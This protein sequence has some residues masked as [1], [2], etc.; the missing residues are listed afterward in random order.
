MVDEKRSPPR[1]VALCA[2]VVA[3]AACGVLVG[4]ARAG[5]SRPAKRRLL[6]MVSRSGIVRLSLGKRRVATITP[7][8]YEKQWRGAGMGAA[9]EGE[10]P[11]PGG[12]L[13]GQIRAPGGGIVDCELHAVCHMPGEDTGVRFTY[14]LTP[15]SRMDLNSLHVSMD[16]PVAVVAGGAYVADGERGNIPRE[17]GN[18]HIRAGETRSLAFDF[19]G[20]GGL[21]LRFESPTPVLLQDNRR[22]GP[23]FSVRMGPQYGKAESWPAGRKMELAFL[24]TAAEEIAQ[25][26]H[27]RLLRPCPSHGGWPRSD[28]ASSAVRSAAGADRRG[29][30][31]RTWPGGCSRSGPTRF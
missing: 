21:S 27:V 14:V 7:G 29:S 6:A 19:P 18:V 9:V 17:F 3:A 23:T 25:Q 28:A 11:K 31:C 5:P 4:T 26:A 2:A 30:G 22:W 10:P 13:R 15:R 24:L 16:L 12:V 8:L 20:G 1:P